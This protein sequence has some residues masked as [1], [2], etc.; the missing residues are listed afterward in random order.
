MPRLSLERALLTLDVTPGREPRRQPWD[1]VNR[2]LESPPLKSVLDCASADGLDNRLRE[3]L[4]AHV[5]KIW[6]SSGRYVLA[7]IGCHPPPAWTLADQDEPGRTSANAR[8]RF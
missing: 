2:M 3:R 1:R 8:R 6:R 4:F 5:P 7:V